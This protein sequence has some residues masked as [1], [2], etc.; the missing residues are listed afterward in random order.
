[1]RRR[2][3]RSPRP[4]PVAGEG[5]RVRRSSGGARRA[6][7][8]RPGRVRGRIGT[9]AW[10][11][12]F[13]EQRQVELGHVDEF[14]VKPPC[15][16]AVRS[17]FPGAVTWVRHPPRR[18][19]ERAGCRW[20][21]GCARGARRPLPRFAARSPAPS[22]RGARPRRPGSVLP[23]GDRTTAGRADA[24]SLL[25]RPARQAAPGQPAHHRGIP[26]RPAATAR[27]RAPQHRHD[28]GT[29]RLGR[30]GRD[31]DLLVPQSPGARAVQLRQDP[32]RPANSDPLVVLLRRPAAPRARAAHPR[33]SPAGTV[34]AIAPSCSWPSRPACESP[35]S[36][37]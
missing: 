16:T 9:G 7:R 10:M 20:C 13:V 34:D 1:M 24:A 19:P 26:R 4:A 18:C 15:R 28:A 6:W 21:A 23:P 27:V 33:T 12:R 31:G 36:P 11:V 3:E 25:H 5:W 35:N 22:G 14:D 17:S 2:Q 32:Q 8:W 30:P 37:A 29:A